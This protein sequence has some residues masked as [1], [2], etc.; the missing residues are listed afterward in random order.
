VSGTEVPIGGGELWLGCMPNSMKGRDL[1]RDGR[2][3]LHSAPLDLELKQGDARV[4]GRAFEV[5]DAEQR[6]AF[7]RASGQD[8]TSMEALVFRCELDDASFITVE[9]DELVVDSWRDGQ[10]PR[11]VRRK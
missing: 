1:L 9:G 2:F 6:A 11:Q 10:P 4:A 5:I 7:W 3:A 8:D